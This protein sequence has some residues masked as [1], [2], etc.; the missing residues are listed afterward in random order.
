MKG[1][2]RYINN[3]QKY[4]FLNEDDEVVKVKY[5]E[6]SKGYYAGD[7]GHIYRIWYDR[8]GHIVQ[9][10]LKESMTNAGYAIVNIYFEDCKYPKSK[11][12]HRLVYKA[13]G[14]TINEIDHINGNKMDNRL[15]NLRS[16]THKENMEYYSILRALREA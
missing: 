7:D 12:V 3:M 15:E 10:Q 14:K 16:C 6:D 9:S 4:S 1:L 2:R 13:F 5:I 8:D 11:T